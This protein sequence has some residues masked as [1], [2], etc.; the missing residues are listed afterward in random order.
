M[1]EHYDLVAHDDAIA[2]IAKSAG[3]TAL[4][5]YKYYHWK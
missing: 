2:E 3:E 4:Q 1:E 5:L